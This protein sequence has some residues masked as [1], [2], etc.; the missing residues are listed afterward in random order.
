MKIG[1]QQHWK[2]LV[3]Y[4]KPQKGRVIKLA[5]TPNKEYSHRDYTRVLHHSRRKY[6][7]RISSKGRG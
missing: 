2:L 6:Q 7:Q 5:I 3:D 4:L 1:L